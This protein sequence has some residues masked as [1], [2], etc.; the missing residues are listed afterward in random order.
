MSCFL[1]MAFTGREAIAQRFTL[2][3]GAQLIPIS[4]ET[5]DAGEA[6]RIGLVPILEVEASR[7]LAFGAYAPFTVLR[8]GDAEDASTGAESLFG[9]TASARLPHVDAKTGRELLLHLTVRGGF[10]TVDARA[11]PFLG[12]GVG[13]QLTW[14][15]R[16]LGVLAEL[17][18]SRLVVPKGSEDVERFLVGLTLG[19]LFRMGGERWDVDRTAS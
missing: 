17:G 7:Y 5:P 4:L 15:D 13:A 9:L 8:A 18:V 19:V 1:A 16:G 12:A 11:G 10:A 6:V 2:G 14:L 3:V